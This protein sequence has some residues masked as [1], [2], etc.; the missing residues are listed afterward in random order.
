MFSSRMLRVR[1]KN[2]KCCNSKYLSYYFRQSS[3][4]EHILN[5]SVGATMPSIN[6]EI[7]SGI[8][9]SLPSISKQLSISE[10]LSCL[11]DKIDLLN[12]QNATLEKMAETLFRQWF[13]E[14]AKKEWKEGKLDDILSIKGGTTPGTSNPKYW[15]GSIYW[16]SPKDITTLNGIYLF[17]TE[18]KITKLGLSQISSGLLP[19]GT[20]LMSSRAPVGTLAFAEVELAINQGYIA[21]LDDKNYPREFLYLWLKVNMNV[22][23]SFSNGSTFMEISKSAF[24]NLPIA[25]PPVE[26]VN[27]FQWLVKPC[28]EKIR[29][30]TIQLRTLTQ[31]RDT[32]LPKLMN[33]EI[34]IMEN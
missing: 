6:T 31:L 17:D 33:G 22:V 21:I 27:S 20:L 2:Q 26:I 25:I 16:T 28:F 15:N 3:F 7:L 29:L 13:I 5:I 11:D 34:E 18:R 23:H 14:G 9:I 12:R 30:N 10:V 19:K 4:R 8:R 1:V 24:K 32:L